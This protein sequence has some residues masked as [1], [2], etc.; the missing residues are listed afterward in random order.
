MHRCVHWCVAKVLSVLDNLLICVKQSS[1]AAQLCT[2]EPAF[3][4][5]PVQWTRQKCTQLVISVAAAVLVVLLSALYLLR[6]SSSAQSCA[7]RCASVVQLCE[8]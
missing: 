5:C 2:S 3:Q 8:L 1:V 7:H 4:T 6:I